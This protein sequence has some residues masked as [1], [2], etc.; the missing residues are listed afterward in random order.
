MYIDRALLLVFA[1]ALVFFPTLEDWVFADAEHWYRPFLI[2]FGVVAA[3][4]W[5]QYRRGADEL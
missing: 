2:W 4:F 1:L 3:A 5:N